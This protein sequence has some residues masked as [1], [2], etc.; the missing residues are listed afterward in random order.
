MKLVWQIYLNSEEVGEAVGQYENGIYFRTT[1][2]RSSYCLLVQV[3]L[4][5]Q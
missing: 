3:P 5:C 1:D 2:S 4:V